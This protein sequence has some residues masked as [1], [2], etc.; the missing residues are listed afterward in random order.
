MRIQ[1]LMPAFW[2]YYQHH[3]I[4][5]DEGMGRHYVELSKSRRS[6]E[7]ILVQKVMVVHG[8]SGEDK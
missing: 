7:V 8:C 2:G 6:Y 1:Q 3:Q 4:F 5:A